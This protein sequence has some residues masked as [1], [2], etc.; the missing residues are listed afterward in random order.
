M[1]RATGFTVRGLMRASVLSVV[2][3]ALAPA[4]VLAQQTPA[5]PPVDPQAAV[6]PPEPPA[7]IKRVTFS[8][9]VDFAN[10]YMFRGIFQEDEGLVIQPFADLAVALSENATVNLGT[11]NSLHTG[12]SGADHPD[13]DA[14]YEADLYASITFI[15]GKW[16]PGVL[17]TSYTSP[18]DAFASVH[19]IAVSLAYDDSGSTV[20]FSPKVLVAFELDGQADGGSNEGIYIELGARPTFP[21]IPSDSHPLTL[22]VPLKLGLSG[23]DYYEGVGGSDTFGY[24]DLG[25]IASV[26]LG[27]GWD[28]H[29]GVDILFL[30]GNM[31]ALNGGENVKPVALI[32]IGLVF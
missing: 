23:N 2:V 26:P 22:A 5:P 9:A 27:G 6:P 10:A 24:F 12:P 30:G 1:R 4:S 7:P 17:W 11:W 16:K 8:G 18:N 21:L 32:G 19:E 31:E 29:G 3:G 13:R 20:P 25:F 28:I 14:W 15:A